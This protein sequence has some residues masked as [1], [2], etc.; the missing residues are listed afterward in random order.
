MGLAYAGLFFIANK[1]S[2]IL[3]SKQKRANIDEMVRKL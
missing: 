2:E 3:T 1:I